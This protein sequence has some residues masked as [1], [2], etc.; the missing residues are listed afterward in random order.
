MKSSDTCNL[1]NKETDPTAMKQIPN[2]FT[3]M[4]LFLGCLA[5]VFILQPGLTVTSGEYGENLVQLPERITWA[6]LCI[7]GAAIVDFLD[8]WVARWLKASS[9]LGAQLDSLSDVVSFGVAP[10]MIVYQFLRYSYAGQPDGLDVPEYFLLPAFFLPLAGAYRLARF[11]IEPPTQG[12]FSGMP[13]P[14]AGIL[15]ATFPLVYWN[16][17]SAW[18]IEMLRNQ[19]FWYGLIVF[20]SYLMVS[21][22]PLLAFKFSLNSDNRKSISI[23]FFILLVSA[24]GF[25]LLGWLGIS[26]GWVAYL[27]VSLLYKKS[28]A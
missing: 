20:C 25:W 26:I 19:W 12:H 28:T 11:N 7:L 8:G 4:N 1:T 2:M 10:A 14:A 24:I 27:F 3:L 21:R 17:D 23:A 15:I 18:Q 22:I 5:L 13:I 9:Q 16:S 6:S